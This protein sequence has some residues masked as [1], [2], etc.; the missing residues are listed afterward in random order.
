ME[1]F[2]TTS[3]PTTEG[4]GSDESFALMGPFREIVVGMRLNPQIIIGARAAT[5]IQ[6]YQRTI[7]AVLRADVGIP[8]PVL[9]TKLTGVK[10]A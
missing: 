9:F 6:K 1:H 7:L 8:R 2:T 10:I 5:D 4:A 3:I